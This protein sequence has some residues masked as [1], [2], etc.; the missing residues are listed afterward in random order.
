MYQPLW[1]N[2]L[3]VKILISHKIKYAR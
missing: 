3:Q 1:I 2:F